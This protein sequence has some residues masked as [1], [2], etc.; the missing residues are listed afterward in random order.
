LRS[1]AI[2]DFQASGTS[3]LVRLWRASFEH[4]V[5]I[6]DP[7]P[8][9]EQTEYFLSRVLPICHVRVAKLEGVLAGFVAYTPESVAQ[10]HVRVENI[11]Q[12]IGST[13]LKLAQD[14]SSGSLRLFTFARNVRACRFYERHGFRAIARGFE[15]TWQLEDVKYCWRR[16]AGDV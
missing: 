2:S 1:V 5:G 13:L 16:S 3:E 11:G 14:D 12:G 7:H 4:G 6:V 15:P 9:S 8:I 10:L